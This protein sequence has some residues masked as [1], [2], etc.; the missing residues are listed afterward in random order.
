MIGL[1]ERLADFIVKLRMEAERACYQQPAD[2]NNDSALRAAVAMCHQHIADDLDQFLHPTLPRG[3]RTPA[4]IQN[5]QDG[6]RAVSKYL[7]MLQEQLGKLNAAQKFPRA[8]ALALDLDS[9]DVA[10][11]AM[12]RDLATWSRQIDA[13]M[14]ARSNP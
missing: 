5:V 4:T 10:A 11:Q 9:L 8:A 7:S 1:E 3:H 6:L 13:S 14:G 2:S 12:G